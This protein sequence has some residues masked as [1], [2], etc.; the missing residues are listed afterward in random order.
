MALFVYNRPDHTQRT[1][2]GLQQCREFC[3]SPLRIFSDGAKNDKDVEPVKQVRQVI[4]HLGGKNV[5]IITSDRNQG[6]ANSIIKGVTALCQEY[7]EAIIIEDDLLVSPHFLQ[8]MNGGLR[9]YRDNEAVMQI[10]G[11]MFPIKAFQDRRQAFFLPM[12]TSWGWAT[13]QRA[14]QHFDRCAEGWEAMATDSAMRNRFNLDGAFNYYR[15]LAHQ[16]QGI[17]DSWAIRWYW[18]VFKRG[19]MALFPP[20]TLVENMGFDGSG[21][22]GWRRSKKAHRKSEMMN[23]VCTFPAM[24][25][26]DLKNVEAVKNALKQIGRGGPGQWIFTFLTRAAMLGQR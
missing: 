7:G 22:H 26:I 23:S 11:H 10:S 5:E 3:Q 19:G 1:L 4:S 8:Y 25:V 13:W 14:W 21:T 16:M 6:L 15:M 9:K 17:G 24:A 2:E 12:T 20:I 18:S